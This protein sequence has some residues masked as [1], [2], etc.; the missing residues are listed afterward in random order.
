[1]LDLKSN[2]KF[3]DMKGDIVGR[4][5][6]NGDSL[7]DHCKILQ[8]LYGFDYIVNDLPVDQIYLNDLREYYISKLIEMGYEMKVIYAITACLIAKT[9]SFFETNSKYKKDI[10][11]ISTKL[12]SLI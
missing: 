2:I 3:L 12:I 4:L 1:M 8:S 11:S 10:W 7:T 9:I 5:T 6:T